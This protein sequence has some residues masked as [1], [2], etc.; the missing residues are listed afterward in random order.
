M[1]FE[2]AREVTVLTVSDVTTEVG[3]GRV[4]HQVY[5]L[6]CKQHLLRPAAR[7]SLVVAPPVEL[8]SKL[9]PIAQHLEIPEQQCGI[10]QLQHTYAKE[11]VGSPLNDTGLIEK[12]PRS[13][14][15]RSR[16]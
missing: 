6:L 9:V 16:P 7:A 5:D 10:R 12:D 1:S 4:D 15:V 14:V 11:R 3:V 8:G 2:P 13:G